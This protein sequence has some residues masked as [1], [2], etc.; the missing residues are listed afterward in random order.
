MYH[1]RRKESV[2]LHDVRWQ[3]GGVEE[4]SDRIA[5]DKEAD[6]GQGT[7]EEEGRVYEEFDPFEALEEGHRCTS[8]G[9]SVEVDDRDAVVAHYRSQWHRSNARRVLKGRTPLTEDEFEELGEKESTVG[10][11]TSSSSTDS[12]YSDCDDVPLKLG[13]S[14]IHFV[15]NDE[16][17]SM[18]RCLLHPGES[19]ISA[20]MFA[21]PLDCAVFLLAGGHFAAGIFKNDKLVAH[22]SFHR[23]V[24]RAKQGGAQSANDK[25][26]GTAHSAGATLRRYNERALR[27]DILKV[28][29][30][31]SDLLAA[32]PLIFIRCASY[33]RVIFYE[34]DEGGFDRK[35]PRLRTIPFETKRPLVD[36]VRRVWDRLGSVACHGPM[37]EFLE[38]R[39]KRKQRAKVLAKKKRVETQ[40][41]PEDGDEKEKTPSK[42]RKTDHLKPA[43]PQVEQGA[44]DDQWPSLDKNTRREL[45]AFVKENKEEELETFINERDTE[46]RREVIDY[47]NMNRF[48]SDNGTFLHLAAKSGAEKVVQF[49]LEA[50][51]DPSIKN[52]DDLVPYSVSASKTVKQVFVQFRSENPE[53]WNW[54]RSHIPEPL[55]LTDEQIAKLNAKKREKKQ[56]QKEK[57]RMKKEAEMK[58]A[59]ELAARAAFLAM[60]DREKRAAAAE[61]RLALLQ[62]GPRCVQCGVAYTGS[63]FEYMELKFC[64]PACIAIHRRGVTSQ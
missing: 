62:G 47:L 43:A 27:E 2:S 17:F 63:G 44:E 16:V 31:W 7:N 21:R 42:E 46:G 33:Q 29:A 35:D 22:K 19:T 55:Q 40:W 26:K 61:A 57:I 9:C 5:A 1:R 39:L 30:T 28:L 8:C 4:L 50:G 51:C 45:Y 13:S 23:Y 20:A 53:R 38:E 54:N 11:G 6:D 37:K 15:H 64:S 49:L 59:E 32:T 14:H 25:T 36:E 18:Y 12:D 60:S 48:S 10:D 3:T 34:L 41:R 58:E 24:V 52:E 56:R